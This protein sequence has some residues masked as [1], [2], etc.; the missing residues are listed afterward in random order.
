MNMT[1]RE[2]IAF[3][4]PSMILMM[5]LMIVPLV[6]TIALSF[7]TYNMGETPRFVGF[8]NYYNL[9]V[10]SP[11]M[12][13]SIGFS[14]AITAINVVV[15]VVLGIAL[16]LMLYNVSSKFIRKTIIGGALIPFSI[17]PVVSTM[18]FS[19]LFK[20]T[21]G[22]L[23]Y[24]LSQVGIN[25]SWF[26]EALPAQALIVIH[27]LWGGVPFTVITLYS[28]LLAMP[29]DPLKAAE[30]EGASL[31][32]KI[33]YVIVPY[34]SP[35]LV[36]N[37]MSAVMAVF[38]TYD[39]VAVMTK[40]GPGSSTETIQFYNMQVAFLQQNIGQGSAIA[41]ISIL[42]IFLLMAPLLYMMYREQLEK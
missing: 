29:L 16:A 20:D 13:S 34:L 30:A 15:R 14:L 7:C 9:I 4:T 22:L 8:S 24:L 36:F 40:G 17:T 6:V 33:R 39:S 18:M 2:F 35:L 31:W 41:I 11:R 28:G 26:S 21:F 27:S 3:S 42:W 12:W 5:I 19:L 37:V 23:P 1:K 32:Q 38:R 10:N 25:I